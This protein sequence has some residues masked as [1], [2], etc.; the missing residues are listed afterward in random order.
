MNARHLALTVLLNIKQ[1]N[2]Y[3]AQAL[4]KAF[5]AHPLTPEDK[6]LVTEIV[7]GTLTHEVL[8]NHW[9]TPFYTGR[10]KTWVKLLLSLT[11]YQMAFLEKIPHYAAIHDA[12]EIA[13][14]R[15]GDFNAKVV[16]RILRLVTEATLDKTVADIKEDVHRLAVRYSHP[17]WLIRLWIA[18]YGMEDTVLML[19]VNNGRPPM[20]IRTNTNLTTVVDLIQDLKAEGVIVAPGNINPDALIVIKGNAVDTKA[21]KEGLFYVQDEGSQLPALALAPKVNGVVLDVCAAPGG[22]TLQLAQM[23]GDLGVVYAHDVYEHKISRMKENAKRMGVANVEAS[24]CS[25][26]DLHTRYEPETF[27]YI[28]VDAPCTGLGVLRRHPEAKSV[29]KPEDLDE[30]MTIQKDIL[31]AVAPLLAPGGRMVYSTCTVNLKE[32]Q[33]QVEGFL[34]NH[35]DFV[36]DADYPARMPEVLRHHFKDGMLQL[37]PQHF[38]TDGFFVACL[39]KL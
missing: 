28:L 15:G 10:V 31:A 21:F 3:S 11:V 2:A 17:E 29:K 25:A 34:K 30:I 16:N 22:K 38:N 23:V 24:V 13:K 5:L 4:D 27:D 39:V 20:V 8:I 6:G 7:Y 19:E 14:A 32:N 37:L 12:V 35:E 1:E 33:R 18:Q 36:L 9:L 26:L